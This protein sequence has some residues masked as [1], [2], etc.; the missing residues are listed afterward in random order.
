MLFEEKITQTN[1]DLNDKHHNLKNLLFD[2]NEIFKLVKL[3][4]LEEVKKNLTGEIK[5]SR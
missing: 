4:E 1:K 2:E 3:L 5:K